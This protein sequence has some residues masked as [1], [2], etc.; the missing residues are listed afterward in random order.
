MHRE[1]EAT[2]DLK[3]N[4]KRGRIKKKYRNEDTQQKMRMQRNLKKYKNAK[5]AN[6]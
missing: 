4:T 3:R 2:K 5:K 1:H 6:K